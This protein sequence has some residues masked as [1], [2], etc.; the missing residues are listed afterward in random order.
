MHYAN[1][2]R[3]LSITL[4]VLLPVFLIVATPVLAKNNGNG[5]GSS[6]LSAVAKVAAD[7]GG[8]EMVDV[9]VQY[10]APPGHSENAHAASLEAQT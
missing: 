3:V 5:N 4:A 1:R 6:K 8:K 7:R 9:I 10:D 2:Q